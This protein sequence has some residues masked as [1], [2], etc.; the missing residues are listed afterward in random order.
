MSS[1]EPTPGRPV[2]LS[3]DRSAKDAELTGAAPAGLSRQGCCLSPAATD[4]GRPAGAP[5]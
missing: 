4:G 1:S 5:V 3:V 2:W